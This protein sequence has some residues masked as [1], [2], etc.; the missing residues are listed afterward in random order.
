MTE[1]SAY[2]RDRLRRIA[3]AALRHAGVVGI[4]PTPLG[5]VADAAGIAVEPVRAFGVGGSRPV[6]GAMWFEER[7][8][9]V[10]RNQSAARMR[11]TQA[12]ELMHALCPWHHAALRTDTAAELFG[13]ARDALESEA[14]AGASMLIFGGAR[15]AAGVSMAGAAALAAAHEASVHATLHH[16]VESDE[17]VSALLVAGRFPRRDGSLPVWRSIESPGFLRHYGC[18]QAHF[19]DGLTAGSPLLELAGHA[20]VSREPPAMPLTMAGHRVVAEAHDNRHAVFVLL[21]S[22]ACVLSEAG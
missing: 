14:N 2:T 1:L 17:G 22:A 18:A 5:A 3:D 20:R 21:T 11:F 15:P 9:F 10:E 8:L 19:P 12:H 16:C 6:L 7:A 13:P 4:V